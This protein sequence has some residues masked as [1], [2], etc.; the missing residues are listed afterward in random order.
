MRRVCKGDP[1]YDKDRQIANAR[2]NYYPT[3]IY[4]CANA[5]EVGGVIREARSTGARVRIRSG[6]HQHEG[7]CTADGILLIDVSDINGFDFSRTPGYVWV[8]AGASLKEIYAR[9]W[10]HDSLFSGGG[11]GDVHVGGLAQGGGWGPVSRAFGLTCDSLAGVE[12]VDANGN[13]STHFQKPGEPASDLLWALRG[14]GGGNFGVVTQYCFKMHPWEHEYTDIT[15]TWTAQQLRDL[16]T[17]VT[18]WMNRFPG[19]SDTRLTTYMRLSAVNADTVGERAVIGG[20]FIGSQ[21][22]AKKKM[23]SLLAGAGIPDPGSESYKPTFPRHKVVA[24][25]TT[26]DDAY[27]ANLHATLGTLPG[28]QPGPPGVAGSA[29]TAGVAGGDAESARNVGADISDT[30]AGVP[31][32]HKISSGFVRDPFPIEAVRRLTSIITSTTPPTEARQYLSFHSLGGAIRNDQLGSCFAFRERRVLLQY[33][34]WWQ[35]TCAHLD[36]SCIKWIEDFRKAMSSFTAG[37][38]INFVDRDI[39]LDDYYG[40]AE[41]MRRLQRIKVTVD[42]MDFFKFEMSIPPRW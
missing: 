5:A 12:I 36:G 21:D 38:F 29:G 2:F 41:N 20:R 15:L 9:L 13:V 17:F 37:A 32:R 22:D 1:D 27:L 23:N 6:G 16:D 7:M 4:Y 10:Q 11:C 18:N 8:G 35:P 25:G 24:E 14:G 39:P 3:C 19:D 30:C 33:Q 31:L 34:A 42:P 40:S 28:Y 26:I